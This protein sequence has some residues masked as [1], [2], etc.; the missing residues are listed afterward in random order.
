MMRL[1]I[2]NSCEKLDACF[3][4]IPIDNGTSNRPGTR[5]VHGIFS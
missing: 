2:V 3:V 5:Q 1:P 4:G